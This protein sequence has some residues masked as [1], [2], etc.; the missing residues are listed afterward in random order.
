MKQTT[1]FFTLCCLLVA[2]AASSRDAT[3]SK[4]EA[5]RVVIS[6]QEI[7]CQSCGAAVVELLERRP[8]VAAAEFDRDAVEIAVSYQPSEVRPE[9]LVAAIETAGYQ[10]VVGVGEGS[11]AAALEF[12]QGLDIEWISR[13]G[14]D[15]DIT[16]HL[17]PGKV[18]VFDFYADWCGPC[19]QVDREMRSILASPDVALRKINVVD[20]GSPVAARY[21]KRVSALPYVIVYGVNGKKAATIGGL[22]IERL[23]RAIRKG[24]GA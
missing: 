14:E 18:T 11:Y 17:V 7:S 6:L 21:L 10:S 3:E 4:P 2:S 24:R 13:A 23:R 22:D 8:G 16:A 1:L 15:V 5:A 12:P 9:D 19:R 20:W